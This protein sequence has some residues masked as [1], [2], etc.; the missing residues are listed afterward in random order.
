MSCP[1]KIEPHQIQGMDCIHIFPVIQWLVKKSI[2]TRQQMSEYLK[3]YANWQFNRCHTVHTDTDQSSTITSPDD[4]RHPKRKY[5]HP[6]RHKL[7]DPNV[8]VRT[9]LLEYGYFDTKST[10]DSTSSAPKTSEPNSEQ[11]DSDSRLN[12]S[13][14][15]SMQTESNKISA[16]FVGAI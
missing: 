3:S 4:V 11:K 12:D 16:A 8:R 14:M 10:G 5:R 13:L 15:N 2:E 6:A 9:T 7:V 1:H